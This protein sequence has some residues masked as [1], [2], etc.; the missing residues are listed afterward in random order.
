MNNKK[1]MLKVRL[2]KLKYSTHAW[3]PRRNK[4]E[5]AI[6]GKIDMHKAESSTPVI[7]KEIRELLIKQAILRQKLKNESK[8]YRKKNETNLALRRTLK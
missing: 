1:G 6:H 5:R 7:N 2:R 4:V 8:Q 3:H